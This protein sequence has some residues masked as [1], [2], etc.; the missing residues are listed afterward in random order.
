MPAR[1][2]A[3]HSLIALD[4]LRAHPKP[5]LRCW[6]LFFTLLLLGLI[7]ATTLGSYPPQQSQKR[8]LALAASAL[9]VA[10]DSVSVLLP[11]AEL[12]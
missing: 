12:P 7:F 9:A 6:N 3:T 2:L 4:R 11:S 10:L 8:R 5:G 1:A